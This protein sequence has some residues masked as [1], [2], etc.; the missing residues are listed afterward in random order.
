MP[1]YIIHVHLLTEDGSTAITNSSSQF[2]NLAKSVIMERCGRK[3]KLLPSST[4]CKEA[5]ANPVW[6][7]VFR[8]EEDFEIE[9]GICK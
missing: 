1:R 3:H 9:T 7:S 2:W 6:T 8:V 4:Y 5:H